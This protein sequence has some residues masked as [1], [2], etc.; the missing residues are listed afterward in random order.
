[1]KCY[2]TTYHVTELHHVH[3]DTSACGGV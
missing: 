2:N 1:M 3:C